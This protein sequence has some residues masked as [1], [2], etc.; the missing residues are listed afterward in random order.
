MMRLQ[1][2]MYKEAKK[3]EKFRLKQ[4]EDFYPKADY[5]DEQNFSAEARLEAILDVIQI[6]FSLGVQK[7]TFHLAIRLFDRYASV[8]ALTKDHL[9][10]LPWAAFSIAVK[11]IEVETISMGA[12]SRWG[13]KEE[14]VIHLE[15]QLF[16]A[17][18]LRVDDLL[19]YHF[20]ERFFLD[21][22]HGNREAKT[23]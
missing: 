20:A 18:E 12:Y 19:P 17:V 2:D 23:D 7:H 14:H 21:G 9:K 3:T 15:R 22:G 6:C 16:Q 10:V 11:Y 1:D 13:L 8:Y 4:V 5:L